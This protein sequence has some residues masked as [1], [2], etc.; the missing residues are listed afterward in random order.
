M[1]IAFVGASSVVGSGSVQL[2][3]EETTQSG[4]ALLVVSLVN[5]FVL[6]LLI[7]RARGS[8]VTLIGAVFLIQ[9]GVETFMSQIETVFFNAAVQMEAAV[10]TTVITFGFLRALIFAPLAVL[11]WGKLKAKPGPDQTRLASPARAEW[12]RRFA[13]LAAAYLVVY[14]LFGYFVAWQFPVVR[15][16]YTG[17]TAI[18]PFHTHLLNMITGSP[19]L[20][21]FQLFR[22]ILWG[23]LALVI[24][25]MIKGKPWMIWGA[26]ALSFGILL[27][28]GLMFPNPYMPAPVREA[29]FIEL[30][31]SMLVYG[32]I[33]GWVW[34][35]PVGNTPVPQYQGT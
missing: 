31:S 4:I 29:H 34:T 17:T 20:L 13:L 8:G 14:I 10:L 12:T 32:V 9:F 35:R 18:V 7:L 26:I 25:W 6:S 24:A 22:G 28:S 16:Y 2:S 5:S 27:S 33:A 23:A 1:V 15:E 11:I 19:V 3:P 21:L 30:L